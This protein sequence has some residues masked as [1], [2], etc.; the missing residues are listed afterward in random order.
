M[1]PGILK[2]VL[3]SLRYYRKQVLYQVL[4]IA[5]LAAVITG[6][7]LTGSSV[8][9]SLKKTA[10]AR[11]GNTGILV[12]TGLRFFDQ[13]LVSKLNDR[14]VKC[15]GILELRGSSLSLE[16]QKE[17]ANTAIY[18]VS[19]G[20]FRF[21]GITDISIKPGHVIVNS[22]LSES[23]ALKD[24]AE[25]VL[26][27]PGISD[28]PADAPFAP[29]NEQAESVVLKT[30]SV[31]AAEKLGNFSLAISQLVPLNV[32][33][34]ISDLEKY[35]GKSLKF[36]RLLIDK[37]S[38][39]SS[40]EIS[41]IL[42]ESL[43]P[44]DIGLKIRPL[45]AVA[46]YEI[47]SDRI[48]IDD[49]ISGTVRSAIPSSR[50][51]ITYLANRLSSASSITPYS[52]VSALPSDIFSD[53]PPGNGMII[54]KWLAEDLHAGEGDTIKMTWYEPDSLNHLI[55]KSE[56]FKVDNVADMKG[57]RADSLLM[58]DFPGIA[59]SESCSNWNAGVPIRM[60]AIRDKDEEYWKTY[61]GTPKAFI[62]YE[63]GREIWGNNYG[64][65]TAIRFPSEITRD[66]I[67]KALTGI[68]EPEKAGF[69]ITDIAEEAI[70]A[71]DESVD[72]S[73]LF[74][75]LGFFLILASVVLL[76]FAVSFYFE[77]KSNDVRTLF[78]LG[79][80]NSTIR[81][82]VFLELAVAGLAGC[83][84][85]SLAGYGFN[86]LIIKALNSV[87]IGAVQTNTLV[88]DFD[89]MPVIIGF[90]TTFI[91][92]GI[93]LFFKV[94]RYLGQLSRKVEYRKVSSAR[95]YKL[96]F[97]ISAITTVVLLIFSQLSSKTGTSLS[98]IA[99]VSLLLSILLGFRQ[100]YV[101]TGKKDRGITGISKR[102]YSFY[103]SH[104]ITPVLFIAAGIFAFVVTSINRKD[105]SHSSSERS[106]GTG[107]YLLWCETSIPINK[108][109]N[110]PTV[111]KEFGLDDDSLSAMSFVQM[112]KYAGSDASCLNL[113]HVTAPPLLGVDPDDF[114]SVNAFSF[115]KSLKADKNISPWQLL[116]EKSHNNTIYGIADQTV[117]EWGLKIA[118]GDTLVMRSESGQPLNIIIA[119]GLQSSVFQGYLLIGQDNFS[120]FY[121]SASGT[122]V[123]LVSGDPKETTMYRNVLNDRLSANGIS[124]EKTDD[125]LASFYEIT[126]TY[127]SV[128]GVFGGLGMIVGVAG[129]GFVILRNYNRRR[130]EL[131][132]LL[133]TGFTF[134]SIRKMIFSEQLRILIAGIISGVLPALVATI[135]SLK[136]GQNIPWMFLAAMIVLI[137]AVGVSAVLLS[138][139]SLTEGSLVQSLKKE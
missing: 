93:F 29:D 56:S 98:F 104:A 59:G 48:F 28:I 75:S 42:K 100:I 6:S 49:N 124:I 135:P 23:L 22:K 128:F 87:W 113:N 74:L 41:T 7:L 33:V 97:L 110:L 72:F 4:I 14:G 67:L 131:A 94:K 125:R 134:A 80:R 133:A 84:A 99:G 3:S 112:K 19:D 25:L 39:L 27:F 43:S 101:G 139:R 77:M 83:L 2:I 106:S 66:Q 44:G 15:T 31:A 136:S 126:N 54:N 85:G 62:N 92:S 88:P 57:I 46:G 37:G 11:L 109:L 138:L 45:K 102:Y 47:V 40:D 68:F 96:L 69:S 115:A 60:D 95:N 70:K 30:G 107:G 81:N 118:V 17:A 82:I 111:R 76:S 50:L 51:V 5:L 34:S 10:S 73:S 71:A 16:S 127:L 52:F 119:A 79:F 35:S 38:N 64:P 12:S 20:F 132:L 53:T 65:A 90:L 21:Q 18:A 108:D 58:P 105:F 24:S 36:N 114:I 8:R 32:F 63:K 137:L 129:L 103:P 91:L 123:M 86:I 1:T 130:R 117:L 120:R 122:P 116:S 13:S 55:E 61:K 121:P 26:K 9:S 78:S 89:I